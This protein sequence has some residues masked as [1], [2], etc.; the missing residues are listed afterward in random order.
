MQALGIKGSAVTVAIVDPGVDADMAN[1]G[2]PHATCNL[3]GDP[4]VWT[5]PGLQ[6]SRLLVNVEDLCPRRL[7]PRAGAGTGAIW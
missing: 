2:R 7:T 6:G 1:A 3:N 4:T 5:G